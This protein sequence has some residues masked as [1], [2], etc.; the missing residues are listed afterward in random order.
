MVFDLALFARTVYEQTIVAGRQLELF[1]YEFNELTQELWIVFN[2]FRVLQI[3]IV[4]LCCIV[5]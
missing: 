5:Y 3:P 1:E 4:K 2:V